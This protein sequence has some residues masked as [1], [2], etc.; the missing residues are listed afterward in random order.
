MS[1]PEYS[2]S[3]ELEIAGSLQSFQNLSACLT[4]P[5]AAGELALKEG[6]QTAIAILSW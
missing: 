2:P 4:E 1:S 5:P 3:Q 6:G